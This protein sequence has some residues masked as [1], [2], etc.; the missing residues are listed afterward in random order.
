M[1]PRTAQQLS[2]LSPDG[3]EVTDPYYEAVWQR[4]LSLLNDVVTVV[5][6]KVAA[7]DLDTSPSVLKHALA[8]RDRHYIKAEW[9][10]YLI[11]KAPSDEI[12]EL[13]ASV[14]GLVV[15]EKRELTADEKLARLESAIEKH[16][17]RAVREA[18]EKDAY[19]PR[20]SE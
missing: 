18:I 7:A 14:R 9:L 4:L 3:Q 17:S 20:R 15:G 10:P 1:T 5:G 11:A 19:G 8:A 13:L 2:L 16:F 6:V 12:V